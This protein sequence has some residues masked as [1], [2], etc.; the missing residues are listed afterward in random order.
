MPKIT[1]SGAKLSEIYQQNEW[2]LFPSN[3]IYDMSNI[4]TACFPPNDIK[5]TITLFKVMQGHLIWYQPKVRI[6]L[7]TFL[8]VNN[9]NLHP[10][11][12]RFP[13]VKLQD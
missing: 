2:H 12:H 11:L 8:L 10:I 9:T 13:V 7:Y 6:G 3:V 4:Q 5:T 1:K